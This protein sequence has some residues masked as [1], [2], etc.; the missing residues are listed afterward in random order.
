MGNIAFADGH[1]ESV[2]GVKVVETK[3]PNAGFDI[4][5]PVDVFWQPT[6]P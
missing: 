2:P 5:P 3:G 4:Q 6:W 1:A